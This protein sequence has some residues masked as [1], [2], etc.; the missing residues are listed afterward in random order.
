MQS[1]PITTDVVTYIPDPGE[2]YLIQHY[3]IKFFSDYVA[4]WFVKINVESI[5]DNLTV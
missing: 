4:E 5:I 3:V 1:V 2:A